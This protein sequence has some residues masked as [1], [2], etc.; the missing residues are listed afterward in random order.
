MCLKSRAHTG[1]EVI[2]LLWVL[3]W[4]ADIVEGI[5]LEFLRV[6]GWFSD[7]AQ[8][9]MGAVCLGDCARHSC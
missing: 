1:G 6:L 2:P 8:V 3:G 4:F 9:A 5:V 7:I